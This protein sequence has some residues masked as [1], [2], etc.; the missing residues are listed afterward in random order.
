MLLTQAT[1]AKRQTTG[2]PSCLARRITGG[3]LITFVL[4]ATHIKGAL[5]Q[6]QN[7][8]PTFAQSLVD[9]VAAK[10][11]PDLIYLGLHLTPQ[12]SP[13]AIIFSRPA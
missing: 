11:R 3:L 9:T 12:S 2:S 4:L 10:H 6:D 13:D 8:K 5:S 1:Q 7:A